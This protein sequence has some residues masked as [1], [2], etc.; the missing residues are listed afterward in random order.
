MTTYVSTFSSLQFCAKNQMT[1]VPP[2]SLLSRLGS[3]QFFLIPQK[4]KLLLK[5]RHFD[6]IDGT[7]TNSLKALQDISKFPGRFCEVRILLVKVCEQGKIIGQTGN[8][9]NIFG[10]LD[11]GNKN[12]AVTQT[13]LIPYDTEF[14]PL[15][16][17]TKSNLICSYR[18][19]YLHPLKALQSVTTVVR[20]DGCFNLYL[21]Y[22]ISNKHH[23]V[24]LKYSYIE[25]LNQT[26]L[27]TQNNIIFFGKIDI[28]IT[29]LA[30]VKVFLFG[31][32]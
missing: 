13:I 7:K 9:S 21:S 30:N 28:G 25:N 5:G 15:L 6:T 24:I 2:A 1:V 23:V 22:Q 12:V 10:L 3:L 32:F 17:D 14:D 11:C 29:N 27:I 18:K 20:V 19:S 4:M 31:T 26:A 8:N 16:N